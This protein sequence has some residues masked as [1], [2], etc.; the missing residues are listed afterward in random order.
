[1]ITK[2][3]E[4]W[5]EHLSDKDLV[6][7]FPY[8][9]SSVAKFQ[10]VKALIQDKIGSIEVAHRGASSM[11]I[12][13]QGEL[14]IYV[15]VS[16]DK[17]D[18]LILPL[19]TLFGSPGSVYPLERARFVTYVD[20]TKAEVFVINNQSKGWLDGVKFEEYLHSHPELIEEYK[21][22]KEEGNGLSTRA[23][24]RRKIEFINE[25]LDRE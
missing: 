16:A 14:D 20:G 4:V 21:T 17:F 9:S 13:G 24:Y 10:K 1:M 8:D 15:P 3:Q 7:F 18:S 22:L 11:G 2:E 6:K 12:S 25:I 23:Y 19:T 5:L